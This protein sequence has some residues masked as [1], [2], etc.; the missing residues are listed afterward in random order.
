MSKNTNTQLFTGLMLPK[1]VSLYGQLLEQRHT[2]ENQRICKNK[3]NA[4]TNSINKTKLDQTLSEES[5][6]SSTSDSTNCSWWSNVYG[7]DMRSTREF[8][9]DDKK[10]ASGIHEKWCIMPEPIVSGFNSRK[11]K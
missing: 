5:D 7:F 6:S 4:N 9:V 11:V 8:I 3:K 10:N 1:C 2:Y